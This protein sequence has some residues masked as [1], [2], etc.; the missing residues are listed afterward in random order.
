MTP[1][2]VTSFWLDE[3]GEK[4]WYN[5]GPDLD[6]TIR[7]RFS[8]A[9]ERIDTLVSEWPDGPRTSL[10]LL[11]LSDQFPRNM[12]RGD[13]RSFATDKLARRIADRA[14]AEGHDLATPEPARQFFY[15]PFEHSEDMGDQNRAVSLF[16]ER[17]PGE[18]LQHAKLHRDTIRQFGRFPW[19]NEALGR[20]TTPQERNLLE[21]GGYAALVKGSVTL[22]DAG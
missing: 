9:W 20:E 14:I 18:N 13:A 19:R 16:Q 1:D 15:L 12:F 11:I 8:E 22:A 3:V 7:D 5:P 17:M 4:G 2:D 10:A 21:A 6:Q